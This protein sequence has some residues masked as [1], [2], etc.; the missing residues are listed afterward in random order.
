MPSDYYLKIEGVK[1]ETTA[2]GLADYMEIDSFSFGASNPSTIGSAG[3]GSGAGKVSL[4][5]FNVMKRTDAASPVLFQACCQGEHYPTAT[6]EIKKPTGKDGEQQTYLK[7]VFTEVYIDSVQW[8]G[9]SGAGAYPSESLSFSFEKVEVNY[10]PQDAKG[11]IATASKDASW[12][13]TTNSSV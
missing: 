3:G 13:V 9:A 11:K 8:S 1:G 4:S 5:S 7:Y 2:K 12:N 6:V 10:F